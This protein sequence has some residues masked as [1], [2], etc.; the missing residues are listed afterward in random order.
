[1]NGTEL[2][3]AMDERE[4][5]WLNERMRATYPYFSQFNGM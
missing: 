1:M 3:G 2:Q 5:A 4:S